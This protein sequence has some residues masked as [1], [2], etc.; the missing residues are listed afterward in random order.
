M[1]A[2]YFYDVREN[3]RNYSFLAE[4]PAPPASSLL[5]LLSGTGAGGGTGTGGAP[6]ARP[7]GLVSTASAAGSADF[8][9]VDARFRMAE[10]VNVR[11]KTT[12]YREAVCSVYESNATA[13]SFFSAGNIESVQRAIEAQVLAKS[14]QQFRAPLNVNDTKRV[15]R[16]T[17]LGCAKDVLSSS[18]AVAA[19]VD[20]L[21]QKVIAHC[22]PVVYS[23]AVSYLKFLN[24]QNYLVVPLMLPLQPDRVRKDIVMSP[25]FF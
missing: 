3:P 22:V 24:D 7:N 12:E 4:S 13:E 19:Q 6:P 10:R 25:Q 21:N 17:Y 9:S 8:N 15:M 11:N 2:E 16:D 18:D 20:Y 1:S 14:G 23:E 5:L